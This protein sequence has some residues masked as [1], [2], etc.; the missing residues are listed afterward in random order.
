MEI[1]DNLLKIIKIRAEEAFSNN[2]IPVSCIIVDQQGN[3][4]ADGINDRQSKNNLLGHAEI[5]AIVKAEEKIGDWRLDG[6]NMLV[7]LE[8]CE[9]C[10]SIIRESR[11]DKVYYIVPKITKDRIYDFG[12]NKEKIDTHPELEIYLSKLLTTF[13]DNKR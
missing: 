13:F 4:I 9:M 8:P 11:L 12:I 2:E 7:S 5:N 3:I 6:Y 10:S 1:N